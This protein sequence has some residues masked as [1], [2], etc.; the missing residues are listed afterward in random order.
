MKILLSVM[1][2]GSLFNAQVSNIVK[3][4][5]AYKNFPVQGSRIVQIDEVHS[6]EHE[7]NVFIFS[8]IEKGA[9]PDKM[10]LE[11]FVK[12]NGQFVVKS[13]KEFNYDGIISSWG[14]RKV[15]ADYDKDKSI[16]AI[17]IYSLNDYDF[18]QESVHLIFSKNNAFYEV[19]SSAENDYATNLYSDN[20]STL[21]NDIKNEIEEYWNKLDKK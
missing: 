21:P 4:P 2:V 10:I 6:P 20:F 3:N 17:F 16:D 12:V 13:K 15:F 7:E 14:Q 19:S 1:F 18:N 8:K 9:K 11:R 5:E